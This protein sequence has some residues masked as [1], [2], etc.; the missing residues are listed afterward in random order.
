[1][2]VAPAGMQRVLLVAVHCSLVLCKKLWLYKAKFD[3]RAAFYAIMSR[4][5]SQWDFSAHVGYR[6]CSEI[7]S[8][9]SQATPSQIR[10]FESSYINT[11]HS[12]RN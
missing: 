2:I 11:V 8:L 7:D 9:F 3:K 5:M 12:E 10:L 1:M 6:T 4:S